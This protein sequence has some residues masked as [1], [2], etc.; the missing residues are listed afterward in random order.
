VVTAV[1]NRTTAQPSPVLQRHR[2]QFVR[3]MIATIIIVALSLS[4]MLSLTVS[5]RAATFDQV[6][7][8]VPQPAHDIPPN[9][10]GT[11]W[12]PEMWR[13]LRRGGTGRTVVP[14]EKSRR[15]IQSSGEQ[16][17]LYRVERLPSYGAWLLAGMGTLLVL[18]YMLRGCVR[19]EAGYSDA[20]VRRF[21][22]IERF[23]HWLLAVSFLML[24]LTGLNM[25][26][27][28][29][30]V[31]PLIGH[32]Y[33]ASVTAYCKLLHDFTGFGFIAGLVLIFVLWVRD[34]WPSQIDLIW[35]MRGGGLLS[36]HD[37]P[38]AKRF[39]AGQKF[40][41]WFV[42]LAGASVSFSGVCLL[43]PFIFAPFSSTFAAL[44]LFGTDLPTDLSAVQEMQLTLVWHG[45]LGIFMIAVIIAHIYVGSIGVEGA[46][47]AMATGDVDENWA[48]QHHSLW[49][50][51]QNVETRRVLSNL[52]HE[53]P[54]SQ[55]VTKS[56]AIGESVRETL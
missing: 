1:S 29:V 15:L 17:R 28:S 37:H 38:P 44:N 8:D 33:F 32:T 39:N 31:K 51:D 14:D 40:I 47:E 18:F 46:F 5:T 36:D 52:S 13:Y 10:E 6:A 23:A 30:V 19:I 12:D 45:G 43:F 35:L 2:A 56:T 4:A 41:F 34:N 22:F 21:G 53:P 49:A 25:L 26:Y 42:V 9:I 48:R 27:G 7:S 50:Q 16:W 54:G 20:V 55:A 24:A 11:P 3:D